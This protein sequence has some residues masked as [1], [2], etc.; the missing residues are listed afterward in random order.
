MPNLDKTGPQGK[1]PLTGRGLGACGC[2]T[3]PKKGVGLGRR[4]GRRQQRVGLENEKN[5]V[6]DEE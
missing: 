2:G 1:G 3:G 5:Q 4:A 6:N